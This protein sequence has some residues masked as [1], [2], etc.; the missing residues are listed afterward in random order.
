MFFPFFSLQ[1]PEEHKKALSYM[2]YIGVGISLLGETVTFIAYFLLLWVPIN[3]PF[4]NWLLSLPNSLD[5]RRCSSQCLSCARPKRAIPSEQDGPILPIR[6]QD[7]LYIPHG[8]CWRCDKIPYFG[9]IVYSSLKLT[10]HLEG[11]GRIRRTSII[12]RTA[13]QEYHCIF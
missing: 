2:T 12:S 8:R 11:F 5:R 1:F 13:Y 4:F 6:A 10:L 3:R 9:G 7:S